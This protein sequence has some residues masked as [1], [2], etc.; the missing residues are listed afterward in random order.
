MNTALTDFCRLLAKKGLTDEFSDNDGINTDDSDEDGIHHPFEVKDRPLPS[1]LY[2]GSSF[3]PSGVT[4]EYLTPAMKSAAKTHRMLEFPVSSGN[5]HRVKEA[6]LAIEH[7]VKP[8]KEE[9]KEEVKEEPKKKFTEEKPKEEENAEVKE[10][11]KE[12]EKEKEITDAE[13]MNARNPLGVL[14]FGG[15]K[16]PEPEKPKEEE[17]KPKEKEE[18]APKPPLAIEGPSKKPATDKVFEADCSSTWKA[19][20]RLPSG[21]G[22]PR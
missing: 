11:E 15:V 1:V 18:A 16:E 21:R 20:D 3:A 2:P 14:M 5:A 13:R 7:E 10:E 6:Q 19:R 12:E 17:G 9:E 4:K 22:S 8:E